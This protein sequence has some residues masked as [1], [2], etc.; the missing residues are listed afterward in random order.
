MTAT[1]P[2]ARAVADVVTVAV[3]WLMLPA[4]ILLA[5]SQVHPVYIA[6]YIVYCLPALALLAATGL[7]G[8][9]RLAMAIP[10]GKAGR[11]AA[12]LPAALILVML[13]ALVPGPQ[14]SVRLASSRPDNL[15]MAAAIMAAMSAL[16]MPCCI[17]HRTS[18][19]LAWPTRR[20]T[21]G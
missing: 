18:G 1:V 17:C 4:A 14:R 21:S 9:T 3:P 5:A 13:A 10:L 15:R 20:L 12:W 7:A 16:V 2:P 8:M 11:V 6:R 19:S